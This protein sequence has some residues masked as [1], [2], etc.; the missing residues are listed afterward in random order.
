MVTQLESRVRDVWGVGDADRQLRRYG[1]EHFR[2]AL[3]A[4]EDTNPEG[5]D[6][7]SGV[8]TNTLRGIAVQYYRDKGVNPSLLSKIPGSDQDEPPFVTSPNSV[9]WHP[10][11]GPAFDLTPVRSDWAQIQ[12]G[13][14]CRDPLPSLC[15]V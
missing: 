6:N 7:P 9:P 4:L 5:L 10:F 3:E 14:L 12:V 15:P 2:L 11:L 1:A 8:F 13:A